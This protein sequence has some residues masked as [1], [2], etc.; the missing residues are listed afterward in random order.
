MAPSARPDS[1][2]APCRL[3]ACFNRRTNDALQLDALHAAGCAVIHEDSASGALRS[4]P[5]LDRALVDLRAGDTL[6]VWRLDRL[7]RSLRDLL[8]VSE[9]LRERDVA[10]RSLTDHI[11]T[12]TAAGRILYAVLGA[13]AQFERDVLRERTVAGLEAAKRR[14]VGINNTAP[15]VGMSVAL[16]TPTP[17]PSPTPLQPFAP[18]VVIPSPTPTP[19]PTATPMRPPMI[20]FVASAAGGAYGLFQNGDPIIVAASINAFPYLPFP[21]LTGS[22]VD[23]LRVRV[24]D[25]RSRTVNP[26]RDPQLTP[27]PEA[28]TAIG[29]AWKATP[30]SAW[31]YDLQKPGRYRVSFAFGTITTDWALAHG[32]RIENEFFGDVRLVTRYADVDRH[33]FPP[34]KGWSGHDL[35]ES[36]CL[37]LR[38]NIRTPFPTM[39][40]VQSPSTGSECFL[41]YRYKE[42]LAQGIE[43]E[44]QRAMNSDNVLLSEDNDQECGSEHATTFTYQRRIAP[45]THTQA[46]LLKLSDG[47]IVARYTRPSEATDDSAAEDAL[48]APCLVL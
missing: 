3:R 30:L 21:F 15:P 11:D 38:V 28:T 46:V 24:Q 18:S 6:V 8:D 41:V 31:G 20:T 36:R 1:R 7:G 45:F 17:S 13:V 23:N 39:A 48:H 12:G 16:P 10:L 43:R 19:Q 2:T 33:F 34:P 42:S 26:I 29:V 40:L 5:G 37:P 14:G 47:Y 25:M 27:A 35:F 4:R 32:Y 44:H 9:M 22:L